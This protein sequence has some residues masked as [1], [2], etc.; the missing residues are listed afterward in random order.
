MWLWSLLVEG[1]GGTT[2]NS[3]NA[4]WASEAVGDA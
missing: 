1:Q 4:S 3:V 2:P